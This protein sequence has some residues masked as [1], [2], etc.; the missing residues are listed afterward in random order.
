MR[1]ESNPRAQLK[2]QVDNL[3]NSDIVFDQF[4]PYTGETLEVERE[5]RG[6]SASISFSYTLYND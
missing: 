4:V 3:L 5:R 6:L 2:L 1:Y